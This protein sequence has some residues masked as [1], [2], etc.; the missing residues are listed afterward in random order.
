MMI[1]DGRRT[2]STF[3]L[4]LRDNPPGTVESR[5]LSADELAAVRAVEPE[6]VLPPYRPE[7]PHRERKPR[8]S[9]A[10]GERPMRLRRDDAPLWAAL[11]EHG[12]NVAA[13]SET[14]GRSRSTV[15]SN[16]RYRAASGD[17]P[18]D[19]QALLAKPARRHIGFTGT[20]SPETRALISI[21]MREYHQRRKAA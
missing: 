5:Y 20:H 12:G 17:I 13:T 1:R 9:R 4:R 21:R 7:R 18:L 2:P 11:R 19:V 10:T 3:D 16:L 15:R 14:L 8:P 6:P